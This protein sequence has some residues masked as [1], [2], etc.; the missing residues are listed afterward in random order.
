MPRRTF[1]SLAF[2]WSGH[3]SERDLRSNT[4]LKRFLV[5]SYRF[6]VRNSEGEGTEWGD[7]ELE[8][9]KSYIGKYASLHSSLST[10]K[11]V[12]SAPRQSFGNLDIPLQP[13]KREAV[14]R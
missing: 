11:S 5:D 13:F 2:V 9:V 12:E 3:S 8:L 10:L 7:L 14:T 4:Q 6:F 1:V